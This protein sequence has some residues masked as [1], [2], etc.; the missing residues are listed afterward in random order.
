MCVYTKRPIPTHD[1]SQ[2]ISVANGATISSQVY[3]CMGLFHRVNWYIEAE[4]KLTPFHRRHFQMYF[5]KNE[6]VR[7]SLK[8][9]SKVRINNI[10]ALVHIMAWRRA[11][12]KPLFAPM[13]VSLLTRI[14]VARPQWVKCAYLEYICLQWLFQ[15]RLLTFEFEQNHHLLLL[16]TECI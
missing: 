4:S 8:F 3:E 10:P 5:F 13:M 12:E 16:L 7:I 15:W 2:S 14:C 6:N 9:V 1:L 11:G